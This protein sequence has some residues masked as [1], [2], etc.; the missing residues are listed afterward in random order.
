V[1]A[2]TAASQKQIHCNFTTRQSPAFQIPASVTICRPHLLQLLAASCVLPRILTH[3][4]SLQ[5]KNA[6]F[7]RPTS[8]A[9]RKAIQQASAASSQQPAAQPASRIPSPRSAVLADDQFPVTETPTLSAT[10]CRSAQVKVEVICLPL[11]TPRALRRAGRTAMAL[12]EMRESCYACR[13]AQGHKS[14]IAP[15]SSVNFQPISV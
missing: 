7:S 13:L 14:V 12:L 6:I 10:R 2:V 8:G 11:W 4:A 3:F 15:R 5:S 9:G 1:Q